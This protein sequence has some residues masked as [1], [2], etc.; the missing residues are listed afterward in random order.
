[1]KYKIEYTRRAQADLETIYRYIALNLLSPETAVNLY[2][3][4]ISKIRSLE[5]MP[6]RNPILDDE[7]F[8]SR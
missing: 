2:R 6:T 5:S 4:I 7:P 1:M 8:K 3:D